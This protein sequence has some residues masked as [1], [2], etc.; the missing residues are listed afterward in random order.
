[1]KNHRE[2]CFATDAEYAEFGNLPGQVKTGCPNT[3][4]LNSRYCSLHAPLCM[5]SHAITPMQGSNEPIAV[6]STNEE[7]IAAIITDKRV[8][9]MSTLYQ[10]HVH[11]CLY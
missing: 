4:A 10:V 8:T 1:M 5:T 7:K 2:V 3:P 6:R 11:V 9:R